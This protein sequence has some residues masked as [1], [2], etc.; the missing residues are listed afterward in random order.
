MEDLSREWDVVICGT[1]PTESI[2]SAACATARKSVLH[3]DINCEYGGCRRTFSLKEFLKY[4]ESNGEIIVNRIAEVLPENFRNSAY[5]IDLM[6]FT[7]YARDE[8]IQILI[9][10]G[11][12]ETSYLKLTEG[13]FFMAQDGT[14]RCIPSSK[15]SIF[16]DKSIGFKQKRVLTRFVS[17]FLKKSDYGHNEETDGMLKIIEEFN[18]K[19]FADLLRHIGF[20]NDLAA[21]FEY[22]VAMAQEPLNTREAVARIKYFVDSIGCYGNSPFLHYLYGSADLPQV[23]CRH[24]AVYGGIFVLDHSP[25]SVQKDENGKFIMEVKEIGKV[26]TSKLVSAPGQIPSESPLTKKFIAH[27]EVILSQVSVLENTASMAVVP[28]N[29]A[30]NEHPVWI[31]Q[32][33]YDSRVCAEKQFLIHFIS[34][35]DI[36]STVDRLFSQEKEPMIIFRTK[37]SLYEEDSLP[38]E[39]AIIVPSPS[40]SELVNGS[41][42]FVNKAK[43]ILQQIDPSIPFF[44]PPTEEI[45]EVEVENKP[46]QE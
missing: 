28:P 2:I 35:G 12:N 25:L 31:L 14:F 23:F 44:P 34:K 37:F 13:L 4:V 29:T 38:I 9:N 46:T 1:G 15:S 32:Y 43:E 26:T 30:G 19:P 11:N 42:Y 33:S 5:C 24:S 41:S 10:S 40:V 22:F 8:F 17:A 27:R 21:S 36:S 6:P 7:I 20:D 39:G 3:L 45:V 16:N 18:D